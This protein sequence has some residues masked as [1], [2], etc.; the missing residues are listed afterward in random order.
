MGSF[1]ERR[2]D[3]LE[4]FQAMNLVYGKIDNGNEKAP[5]IYYFPRSSVKAR[6]ELRVVKFRKATNEGGNPELSI[7]RRLSSHPN[8][9]KVIDAETSAARIWF[10][11]AAT[12]TLSLFSYVEQYASNQLVPEAFIWHIFR[13]ATSVLAFMHSGVTDDHRRGHVMPASHAP[14]S[15]NAFY[16]ENLMLVPASG[17]SS[18]YPDLMVTEF[19]EAKRHA[20]KPTESAKTNKHC[21][22]DLSN[23]SVVLHYVVSTSSTV[24]PC[25]TFSKSRRH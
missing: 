9:Q 23:L 1:E 4:A 11:S 19:S 25:L 6:S 13:Q 5:S 15:H 10:A 2:Y 14:I 7:L 20:Y 16:G 21:K 8:V 22:Y 3:A 18:G 17:R 24:F 12:S